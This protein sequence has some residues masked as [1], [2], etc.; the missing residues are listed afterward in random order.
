MKLSLLLLSSALT[1]ASGMA[2]ER[3]TRT[4]ELRTYYAAPGKLDDL[5]SRFRDHTIALFKETWHG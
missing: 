5:Q 2:A 1:L 4:F 3:E